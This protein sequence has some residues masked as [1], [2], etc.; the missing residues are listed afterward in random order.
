MKKLQELE[1]H[2][3]E[4]MKIEREKFKIIEEKVQTKNASIVAANPEAAT[5]GS[6]RASDRL[7]KE[8]KTIYKSD[9]VK[10]GTYQV[11]N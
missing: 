11:R 3:I 6:V 9:L 2:R 10:G 1:S 8:L 4:N 5:S 7:M